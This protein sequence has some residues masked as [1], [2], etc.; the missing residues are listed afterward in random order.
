[1][2]IYIIFVRLLITVNHT[3]QETCVRQSAG[4]AAAAPAQVK[5]S[6]C[7]ALK[8]KQNRAQLATKNLA[9]LIFI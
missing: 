1:M 2:Y 5:L 7:N 4:K 6:A 3:I 8:I 9:P